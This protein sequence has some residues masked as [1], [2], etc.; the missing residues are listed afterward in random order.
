VNRRGDDICRQEGVGEFERRVGPTIEALMERVAE[1]VQESRASECFIAAHF[2]Y[3]ESP[4]LFLFSR[5][6]PVQLKTS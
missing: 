3:G 5:F 2:C 4:E 1:G 6:P